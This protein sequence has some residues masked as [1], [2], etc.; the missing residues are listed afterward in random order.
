MHQFLKKQTKVLEQSLYVIMDI[1]SPRTIRQ[2]FIRKKKVVNFHN[3]G[4]DPPPPL[5]VVKGRI[6]F[7]IHSMSYPFMP[8]NVFDIF[9]WELMFGVTSEKKFPIPIIL[10]IWLIWSL[11]ALPYKKYIFSVKKH[12][13]C[14]WVI[15]HLLVNIVE[16]S[17]CCTIRYLLSKLPSK[18][19][20]KTK[21][22]MGFNEFQYT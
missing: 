2:G 22:G 12:T 18:W 19:Q 5:K 7:S 1:G 20:S 8:K 13:F 3:F 10:Y 14:I 15:L 9:R 11:W 21:L 6:F 17:D 4:P 16:I